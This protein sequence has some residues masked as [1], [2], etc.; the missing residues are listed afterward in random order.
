MCVWGVRGVHW[1]CRC[2]QF[3]CSF[4]AYQVKY[5][6]VDLYG[7]IM[8]WM[9]IHVFGV[10]MNLSWRMTTTTRT[11]LWTVTDGFRHNDSSARLFHTFYV[12]QSQNICICLLLV[13][14]KLPLM[15]QTFRATNC[16]LKK[17]SA[18]CFQLVRGNIISFYPSTFITKTREG[19][20][21]ISWLLTFK[22]QEHC[23]A[24][25]CLCVA[26]VDEY[27]KS[28][29]SGMEISPE[30]NVILCQWTDLRHATVDL[31]LY[32]GLD[33]KQNVQVFK[34]SSGDSQQPSGGTWLQAAWLSPAG[35]TPLELSSL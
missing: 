12:Q 17:H 2:G 10:H 34:C 35:P 9:H 13:S 15:A 21:K 6:K 23:G 30:Y 11:W 29:R 26:T 16:K 7:I 3:V 24:G 25:N 5:F 4:A 20:K 18:N 28:Y 22:T 32:G 19:G 31:V 14:V 1:Q 27:I 8:P 33:V